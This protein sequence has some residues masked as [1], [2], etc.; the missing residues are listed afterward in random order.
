[1]RIKLPDHNSRNANSHGIVWN[2][3]SHHSVGADYAILSDASAYDAYIFSNPAT[4]PDSNCLLEPNRL[5]HNWPGG[6]L[7]TVEIVGDINIVGRENIVPD[8]HIAHGCNMIVVPEDTA[9]PK[10]QGSRRTINAAAIQPTPP[11]QDSFL[12]YLYAI[13]AINPEWAEQE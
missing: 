2:I 3:T 13:C 5:M 9:L 7:I 4:L 8:H 12:T 6:V 11:L 1:M 10:L